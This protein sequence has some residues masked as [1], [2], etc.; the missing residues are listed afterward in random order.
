MKK[1]IVTIAMA[2]IMGTTMAS[3]PM[4]S[5]SETDYIYYATGDVNHDQ[6]VDIMDLSILSL[7]LVEKS[8]NYYK[9]N[10]DMDGDGSVTL[11]DLATLRQVVSKVRS[12]YPIYDIKECD[13][14]RSY[15]SYDMNITIKNESVFTMGIDSGLPISE[16][17]K[18]DANRSGNYIYIE[19][20]EH[21]E[22]NDD[23]YDMTDISFIPMNTPKEITS[24]EYKYA[25]AM[26]EDYGEV[27]I[28]TTIL[29]YNGGA[30]N[31]GKGFD[32]KVQNINR[33]GKQ[34]LVTSSVWF[35]ELRKD[36]AFIGAQLE[37]ENV[38][39]YGRVPD[40]TAYWAALNEIGM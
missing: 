21:F 9:G 7:G 31:F 1:A 8:D 11:A 33:G 30:E 16:F 24:M 25:T 37:C 26:T 3:M 19:G 20:C 6:K 12:Q 2:T 15:V 18:H 23:T 35:P 39:T 4:V 38:E 32:Y 17:W 29:H 22:M 13:E 34:V 36:F 28:M 10:A 27:G 40:G 5:A 14:V